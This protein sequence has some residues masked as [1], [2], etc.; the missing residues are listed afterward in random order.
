ML[1][2][3]AEGQVLPHQGDVQRL[4][5]LQHEL[6]HQ[7]PQF[8]AGALDEQDGPAHPQWRQVGCGAVVAHGH[9]VKIGGGQGLLG[10]GGRSHP[11]APGRA[12]QKPPLIGFHPLDRV[13]I[14]RVQRH[15]ETAG[16]R[17]HSIH[18]GGRHVLV[19]AHVGAVH[20]VGRVQRP[21]PAEP[22]LMEGD[23]GRVAVHR[24]P[25]PQT[26]EGRSHSSESGRRI[27]N[28]RGRRAV[29]GTESAESETGYGAVG[30]IGRVVGARATAAGKGHV[31]RGHIAPTTVVDGDADH[32][33]SRTPGAQHCG[34]CR[35]HRRRGDGHRGR[36]GIAGP[37]DADDDFRDHATGQHG[38]GHGAGAAPTGE[39]NRRRLGAVA[40]TAVQDVDGED[41]AARNVGRCRGLGR[42]HAPSRRGDG[43][44]A[45]LRVDVGR[46]DGAP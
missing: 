29:A 20:T 28:H 42:D 31:G 46:H 2:D 36:G 10:A 18:Q 19:V 30:E 3:T 1:L 21:G 33:P 38:V 34:S 5:S 45:M 23:A 9:D 27:D 39:S 44:P 12:E 26:P 17:D 22:I 37:S 40:P 41:R 43:P 14:A 8:P 13:H 15:G 35:L 16:I 25:Q 24:L 11:F 6:I 4:E 7:L 32:F